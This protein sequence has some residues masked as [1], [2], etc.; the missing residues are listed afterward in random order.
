MFQTGSFHLASNGES[1]S[2]AGTLADAAQ[3]WEG[4]VGAGVTEVWTETWATLVSA[5]PK[6]ADS[7]FNTLVVDTQGAELE[8]LKSIEST[9]G[10][11][12]ALR[13]LEQ[14]KYILV[15]VSNREFYQGQTLQP[16]L[17]AFLHAH[18]FVNVR[19]EYPV[20]GDVLYVSRNRTHHDT[21]VCRDGAGR[22][23][24]L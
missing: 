10:S 9:R 19:K 11:S 22:D 3:A 21:S 8:I 17:E 18:G 4:V 15:E 24:D 20:H 14:F 7:C 13:G 16:S 6:L 23:P 12:I 1:S 5:H 2:L